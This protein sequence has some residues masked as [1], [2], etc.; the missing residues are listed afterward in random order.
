MLKSIKFSIR[1]LK[2]YILYDR[3]KISYFFL[4]GDRTHTPD[5]Q[6]VG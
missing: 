2:K 5:E 1:M 4:T 6:S 3:Y